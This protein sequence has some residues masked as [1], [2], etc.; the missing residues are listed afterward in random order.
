VLV[1]ACSSQ[2][3][4]ERCQIDNNKPDNSNED[5]AGGLICVASKDLSNLPPNFKGQPGDHEGRCCPGSGGQLD[6]TRATV[7][8]CKLTPSLS[9]AD[10]SIPPD[11]GAAD[12]ASDAPPADAPTTDGAPDTSV[13]TGTDAPVDAP[14]DAADSG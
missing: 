6:P 14:A 8:E 9:G 1:V 10:S 3:E 13:D 2:G 12:G 5:C 11:T 7:P 4:G